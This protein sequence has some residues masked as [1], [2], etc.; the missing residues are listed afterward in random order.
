MLQ[1][2]FFFKTIIMDIK[3]ELLKATLNIY[4]KEYVD[5]KE[6]D[7][8]EYLEIII[9]FPKSIV[10]NTISQKKHIIYDLYIK[11]QYNFA[12]G[13]MGL[14]G[15]RR[16]VTLNEYIHK[17]MHSH[18]SEN[19]FGHFG[20][21][22]LGSST[23]GKLLFDINKT[24]KV[25][26]QLRLYKLMLSILPNLIETESEQG[27]PYIKIGNLDISDIEIPL[28]K[29]LR[30]SRINDIKGILPLIDINSLKFEQHFINDTII[31]E[32]VDFEID[33]DKHFAI[34]D[35]L[36]FLCQKH[37][38]GKFYD[39][40]KLSR[41]EYDEPMEDFVFK[42][43]SI[44]LE[45]IDKPDEE[46]DNVQYALIPYIK[47]SILTMFNNLNNLNIIKKIY[48]STNKSKN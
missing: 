1:F 29:E 23:I 26:E 33:I 40:I 32:V 13:S 25:S 35:S 3:Y 31:T 5:Y 46:S 6:F 16:K 30:Y 24:T 28:K 18:I 21:F 43:K 48:G 19:N 22:C 42:N 37:S 41:L 14:Y 4:E 38:N 8:E 2:L 39:I 17:Y 7:N 15:H 11:I 47:N 10:T 34:L 12:D 9:L 45:I 20:H 44:K 27:V 36:S